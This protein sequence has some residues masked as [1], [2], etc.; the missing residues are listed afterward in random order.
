MTFLR[1]APDQGRSN[2]STSLHFVCHLYVLTFQF[3][4]ILPLILH[5][6]FAIGLLQNCQLFIVSLFFFQIVSFAE[7]I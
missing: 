7:I 6:S 3:S 1:N 2:L 4:E 5:F